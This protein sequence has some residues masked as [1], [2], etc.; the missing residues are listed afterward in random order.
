MWVNSLLPTSH[1]THYP[2]PL[3]TPEWRGRLLPYHK[4]LCHLNFSLAGFTT[5]SELGMEDREGN[6]VWF[7]RVCLFFGEWGLQSISW[8]RVSENPYCK[9]LCVR[10]HFGVKRREVCTIMQN[11]PKGGGPSIKSNVSWGQASHTHA[12]LLENHPCAKWK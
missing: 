2:T 5:S 10:V 9:M 8:W 3:L 12:W 11:M 1:Y 7:M 6:P 4:R